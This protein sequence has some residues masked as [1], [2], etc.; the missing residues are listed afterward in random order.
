MSDEKQNNYERFKA[1]GLLPKP[2]E[3]QD[4]E[5]A[6]L[7][8]KLAE[9]SRK[10]EKNENLPKRKPIL[11]LDFDGVLHSYVS[12]WRGADVIPDSAVPGSITFL[13]Q[14]VDVFDVCVFSSRS[15][16]P[17][18]LEAMQTWC[19]RQ[20]PVGIVKKLRFVTEKPPA[21]MTLDDR[22]VTF[23]GSWPPIEDLLEFKPWNRRMGEEMDGVP[24][25]KGR[26]PDG[27][28]WVTD[29]TKRQIKGRI[30]TLERRIKDMKENF[31]TVAKRCDS[32]AFQV[33]T[34]EA[35]NARKD[36]VYLRW[37]KILPDGELGVDIREVIAGNAELEAKV[38][39]L[40]ERIREL[41]A[42]LLKL[43]AE[44]DNLYHAAKQA[45]DVIVQ[46]HPQSD[47][48]RKALDDGTLQDRF[49]LLGEKFDSS[50]R[51]EAVLA[52]SR[53]IRETDFY[54]KRG[55]P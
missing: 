48:F 46:T 53:A 36:D 32:L 49:R 15:L 29:F 6:R 24:F 5:C 26:M 23:T 28:W 10:K 44:R 54:A 40:R 52:L 7:K 18:G 34:L 50:G 35:E 9:L 2:A 33:S 8:E 3:G 51:V 27:G 38:V 55:K 19:E 1:L 11:C 4:E 22:A 41:E 12:G 45:L 47:V 17:G 42:R 16:Q 37:Q 21:H 39:R 13:S 30:A 31:E 25:F 20:Y 43:C 14:A